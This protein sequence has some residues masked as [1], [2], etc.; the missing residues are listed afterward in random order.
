MSL[1]L[2]V[3]GCRASRTTEPEAVGLSL[4]VDVVPATLP[5]DTTQ[6]AT[7]WITVLEGPTP[8]GDSTRVALIATLGTVPEVAYTRDGL[9][10]AE[11]RAGEAPGS[12]MLI[13][14]CRGVRDTM[15]ITLH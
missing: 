10:T 15:M 4:A 14:Q 2:V 9:A 11:F 12:A 5:A 13:A 1:L 7:V 3:L 8:V 6:T